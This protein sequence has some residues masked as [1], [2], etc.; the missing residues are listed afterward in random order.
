M[1]LLFCRF[2]CCS[3]GATSVE[4]GLIAAAIGLVVGAG[5]FLLGDTVMEFFYSDV[6]DVL[7]RP[8][9]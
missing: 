7:E 5:A 9:E 1:L 6:A 8:A 3:R 4:Y 2:L